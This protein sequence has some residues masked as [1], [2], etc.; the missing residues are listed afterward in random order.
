[1]FSVKPM[2]LTNL[3][4]AV[5]LKTDHTRLH[6]FKTLQLSQLFKH[7]FKCQLWALRRMSFKLGKMQKSQQSYLFPGPKLQPFVLVHPDLNQISTS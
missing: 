7:R 2:L 4:M 1:M 6:C 5:P 3:L